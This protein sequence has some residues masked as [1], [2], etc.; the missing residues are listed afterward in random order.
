MN[1]R[2]DASNEADE[3]LFIKAAHSKSDLTGRMLLHNSKRLQAPMMFNWQH[4]AR[5]VMLTYSASN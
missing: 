1:D 2:Y 3:P 4:P 5:G